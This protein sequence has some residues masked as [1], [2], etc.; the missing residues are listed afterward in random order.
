MSD[1][2]DA[3]G[4]LVRDVFAAGVDHAVLLLR[5][6]AR[7]YEP[8]LHDLLNPLTEA[9]RGYAKQLGAA[10]PAGLT[11]RGYA[12]PPERCLDTAECMLNAYAQAGGR[13]TRI[14]PVEALGVFYALDQQRMWVGLRAAGGL[15][16]YISEWVA[17]AVPADAIM[18]A[19][20]AASLVYR[21]LAGRLTN[22]LPDAQ[23]EG[24]GQLDVCV[25]HDMTI[26]LLR[27][28]LLEQSA[29]AAPVQYLDG[30]VLYQQ[31]QTLYLRSHDGDAR[32]VADELRLN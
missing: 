32:V 7:T 5:H 14:R 26:H 10:L 18:P 23:R 3:T 17:G 19:P 11:L 20:L 2:G 1:Y 12:S 24:T 4:D 29:T 30:M 28:T 31:D 6:S 16:D 27:A 13:I 15:A 22:P 9:G 8:G 25:T 21:V